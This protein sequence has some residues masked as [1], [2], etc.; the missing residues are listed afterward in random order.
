LKT[1]ERE[2]KERLIC[3]QHGITTYFRNEKQETKHTHT[4]K[5]WIIFVFF[6]LIE[7]TQI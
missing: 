5:N 1:H 4:Q 6:E 3:F 7:V 2:A